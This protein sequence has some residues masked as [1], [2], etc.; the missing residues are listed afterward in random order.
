[1]LDLRLEHES[2]LE[3]YKRVSIQPFKERAYADIN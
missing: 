3:T 2:F 1:Y